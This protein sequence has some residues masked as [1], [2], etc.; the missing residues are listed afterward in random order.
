MNIRSTLK[1]LLRDLA[2]LYISKI[3]THSCIEKPWFSARLK[4]L[5]NKK[6]RLYRTAELS[7]SADAWERHNQCERTSKLEIEDAKK[8]F[9]TEDLAKIMRTNPKNFWTAV[10]PISLSLMRPEMRWALLRCANS[11][12]GICTT[13]FR[14]P[15]S[16]ARL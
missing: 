9:F 8:T 4:R 16:P 7:R 14:G 10:N 13:F 1:Y 15:V 12:V 11:L 6:R 5:L 2:D 3:S